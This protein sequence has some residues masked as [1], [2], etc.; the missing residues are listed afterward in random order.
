VTAADAIAVADLEETNR[1]ATE[2]EALVSGALTMALVQEAEPGDPLRECWLA[3]E[4]FR[5]SETRSINRAEILTARTDTAAEVAKVTAAEAAAA[6]AAAL[7]RHGSCRRRGSCR[8]RG[9]AAKAAA[10]EL[11]A[12]A[13]LVPELPKEPGGGAD[14]MVEDAEEIPGLPVFSV[15]A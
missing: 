2:L 14:G 7:C 8:C 5:V 12:R 4:R 9:A 15:G 1:L 11:G 13:A 6:K 3:H 10:D